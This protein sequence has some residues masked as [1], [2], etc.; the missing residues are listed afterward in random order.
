MLVAAVVVVVA[1]VVDWQLYRLRNAVRPAVIVALAVVVAVAAAY[2]QS[3]V[4]VLASM[5][6]YRLPTD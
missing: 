5:N 4:R 1:V 2:C 3:V 6:W